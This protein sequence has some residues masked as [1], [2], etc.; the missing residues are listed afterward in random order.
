MFIYT[1]LYC[2]GLKS[3]RCSQRKR[4]LSCDLFQRYR[5]NIYG[6]LVHNSRGH[7]VRTSATATVLPSTYEVTTPT[8]TQAS[9]VYRY[10]SDSYS[11]FWGEFTIVCSASDNDK[12]RL[13]CF[14]ALTAPPHSMRAKVNYCL[15][16]SSVAKAKH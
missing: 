10:Y 14:T 3:L 11:S 2:T 16:I 7:S 4:K 12:P 8:T 13:F 9:A 1:L 6:T 15:F 5:N